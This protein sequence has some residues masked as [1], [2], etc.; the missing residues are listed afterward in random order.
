MEKDKKEITIY[1][2][3]SLI[4]NDFIKDRSL[5]YIIKKTEKIATAIYLITNFFVT[6]EPIKWDLR[7]SA[8]KLL[9]D[10]MSL[11]NTS[12]SH[13]EGTILKVQ[14]NIIEIGA[15]FSLAYNSG[16]ISQM[17]YEII[18]TEI[19]NLSENVNNYHKDQIT[20]N[21]T[22][23]DDKYFNVGQKDKEVLNKKTDIWDKVI[24]DEY[25]RKQTESLKDIKDTVKDIKDSKIMFNGKKKDLDDFFKQKI[26]QNSQNIDNN[27]RQIKIK[28]IV[29]EKGPV[30]IKDIHD[31][32]KEVSEKTIQR[33]LQKM[34]DL[35]Q[36][37]KEG[38]RRWTKY[39][40]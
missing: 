29:K 37:R 26:V 27:E 8:T 2:Q 13:K 32:F 16:F 30:T 7:K 33:E 28:N 3:N 12:F 18:F 36:V 14:N 39:F 15:L 25:K 22:L 9:K 40:I 31:I 11:N 24:S 1:G 6:E 21:K 19:N 4:N 38:E 34:V 5:F 10:T 17:N 35:G 20:G 23:F